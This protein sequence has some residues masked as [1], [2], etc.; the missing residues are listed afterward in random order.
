MNSNDVE[1]QVGKLR[2]LETILYNELHEV[3]ERVAGNKMT[4]AEVNGL[5]L[6]IQLELL[7]VFEYE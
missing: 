7:G 5:L 6:Q 2:P 3:I 4:P 1:I